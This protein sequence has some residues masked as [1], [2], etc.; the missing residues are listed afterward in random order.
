MNETRTRDKESAVAAHADDLA[1]IIPMLGLVDL[2][3][4]WERVRQAGPERLRDAVVAFRADG[5]L[6]RFRSSLE[7]AV[8]AGHWPSC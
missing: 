5:D 8:P 7:P 3:E 2:E 4:F 1:R 6:T